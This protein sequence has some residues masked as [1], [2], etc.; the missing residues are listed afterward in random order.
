MKIEYN[1]SVSTRR[2]IHGDGDAIAIDRVVPA[3]KL[4]QSLEITF[5]R[6]IRVPDNGTVNNLP[7]S[8]GSF[9]LHKIQNYAHRLPREIAEKG[10]VF[11]SMYQKEAMW[12][13]FQASAPFMIKIYMGGVNAV[14]GEHA[15]E[16]SEAKQRRAFLK[17]KGKSIQDYL[18]VPDQDWI[19]GVAVKPG[20]VRQFVAMPMGA[21]YSVEAQLTGEETVGGIQ[22]EITPGRGESTTT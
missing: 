7:P 11:L 14:S 6:T 18:V 8:L 12:M 10:G 13:R 9:D 19:D 4:P 1:F 15:K 2:S 22:L 5:E 16:T 3:G 20:L 17:K 21:G